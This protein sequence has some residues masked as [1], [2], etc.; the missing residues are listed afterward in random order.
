[1]MWA[2]NIGRIFVVSLCNDI[3]KKQKK[4]GKLEKKN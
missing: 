4:C 2:L 3:G 1:M